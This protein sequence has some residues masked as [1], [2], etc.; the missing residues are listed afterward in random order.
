M[1][2]CVEWALL[3]ILFD[4]LIILRR[5]DHHVG[6]L[7]LAFLSNSCNIS[8]ECSP[9]L[10]TTFSPFLKWRNVYG[11]LLWRHQS[12]FPTSVFE[13]RNLS[14]HFSHSLL[15]AKIVRKRKK[16][17]KK[18]TTRH[19]LELLWKYKNYD[20]LCFQRWILNFEF[21]MTIFSLFHFTGF[22]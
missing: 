14:C 12:S 10:F 15:E 13:T 19:E 22:G 21:L 9:L 1:S 7:F 16:T 4:P 6:R 20:S 8:H 3:R 2:Q 11:F 5:T 18:N 17:K